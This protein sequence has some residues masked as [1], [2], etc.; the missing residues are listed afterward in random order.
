[1]AAN[2]DERELILG[3][4]REYF[5]T[6]DARKFRLSIVEED[7]E[8]EGKWWH[9]PVASGMPHVNPFD[10]APELNRI[11]EEFDNQGT[12]LLLIPDIT[13]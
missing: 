1:M 13:E 10:Y 4:L 3:R 6:D 12:K 5:Q 9:V 2:G 11:E 8:H 7:I